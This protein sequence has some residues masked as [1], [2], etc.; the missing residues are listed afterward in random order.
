M[1]G[2]MGRCSTAEKSPFLGSAYRSI[3][4]CMRERVC[5]LG[6]V[7]VCLPSLRNCE[8][9]GEASGCSALCVVWG[10]C[11][12]SGRRVRVAVFS[13]PED[14]SKLTWALQ[15]VLKAM[16]WDEDRFGREYDLDVFNVVCAK[17]FNMGAMENKGLNIFNAALLLADPKTTT[18]ILAR[19]LSRHV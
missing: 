14:S 9:L 13:E 1:Y 11:G 7:H 16:K 18:G 8:Q 15:S 12:Q 10:L 19:Y 4:V 17:D 2:C 6:P 5:F 3:F